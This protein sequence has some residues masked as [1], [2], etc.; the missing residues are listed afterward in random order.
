[1]YLYTIIDNDYKTDCGES[2]DSYMFFG[3]FK[4]ARRCAREDYLSH[5]NGG[6]DAWAGDWSEY[7]DQHAKKRVEASVCGTQ[8]SVRWCHKLL[9]HF[10]E[11]SAFADACSDPAELSEAQLAATINDLLTYPDAVA[12]SSISGETLK[13]IVKIFAEGLS[14]SEKWRTAFKSI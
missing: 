1:M 5:T 8:I 11:T 9:P 10:T 6:A 13:A 4:D 2:F 3:A 14:G 12:Y 7:D